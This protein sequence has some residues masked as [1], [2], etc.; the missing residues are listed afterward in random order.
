MACQDDSAP[1][2]SP[3]TKIE[4]G[5]RL[6]QP[7]RARKS[8]FTS[9]DQRMLWRNS[10]NAVLT[11]MRTHGTG[12]VTEFMDALIATLTKRDCDPNA[13]QPDGATAP[14]HDQLTRRWDWWLTA[15]ALKHWAPGPA[16]EWPEFLDGTSAE[17]KLVRSGTRKRR[18]MRATVTLLDLVVGPGLTESFAAALLALK[19]L[20]TSTV[21]VEAT[22][23]APTPRVGLSLAAISPAL[24]PQPTKKRKSEAQG[25][26]EEPLSVCEDCC[27]AEP[28]HGLPGDPGEPGCRFRLRWCGTCSVNHAG[29]EAGSQQPAVGALPAQ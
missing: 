12:L 13:E 3:A 15:R 14:P 6:A 10:Y 7:R 17:V 24:V 25:G 23:I 27:G 11:D 18:F 5:T 2:P 26:R 28:A 21:A 4:P 8:N 9:T 29:A 20:G 22:R 1:P 16:S 19:A